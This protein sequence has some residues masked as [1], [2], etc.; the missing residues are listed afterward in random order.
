[1]LEAAQAIPEGIEVVLLADRGFVDVNFM[2]FLGKGLHR[3]R[4]PRVKSDFRVRI[5][6][7]RWRK[8]GPL[9]P[10]R[11]KAVVYGG[12][13]V[14]RRHFG[15]VYPA[16]GAPLSKKGFRYVQSDEPRPIFQEYGLRTDVE[17]NIWMTN[18]T[19]FKSRAVR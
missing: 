8:V 9:R 12:V 11:G 5:P 3:H 19:A 7:H 15:P 18:P 4:R 17:E 13:L 16:V 1:M 10:E 2:Q 6:G 14:T